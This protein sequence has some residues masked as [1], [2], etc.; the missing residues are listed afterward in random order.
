MVFAWEN[1]KRIRARK[2]I[3]EEGVK[4][5]EIYGPLF[6]G[7]VATFY[8]KFDVQSDP[9]QVVIDFSE[10]RVAD[11]SA[12]DALN[13]LSERYTKAGKNLQLR[14]LSEDCRV[15]LNNADKLIKVNIDE[16]PIYKVMG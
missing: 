15:L 7:S 12:I 16:D 2:H 3:D 5:Y 8:E 9:D 11:M 14:H 4:H 10:S 13:T 1:A 6:F